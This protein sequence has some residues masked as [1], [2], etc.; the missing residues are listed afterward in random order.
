MKQ[1]NKNNTYKK[2]HEN[3]Y[4]TYYIIDANKS[5][6][7]TIVVIGL[8]LQFQYRSTNIVIIRGYKL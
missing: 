7:I 5:G 4:T 8:M 2:M 6:I 3:M 1:K